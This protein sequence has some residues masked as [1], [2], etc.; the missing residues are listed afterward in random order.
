MIFFFRL[1]YIFNTLHAKT[2]ALSITVS[3]NGFKWIMDVTDPAWLLHEY[4]YS[5]WQTLQHMWIIVLG[6]RNELFNERHDNLSTHFLTHTYTHTYMHTHCTLYT[7]IHVADRQGQ[8]HPS[9]AFITDRT[10]HPNKLQPWGLGTEEGERERARER[11]YIAGCNQIIT[12]LIVWEKNW[13]CPC[14]CVWKG[15]RHLKSL[16]DTTI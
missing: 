13:R 15:E 2:K 16:A 3:N 1:P 5:V 10:V 9:E 8:S 12:T 7:D 4:Q 11:A 6:L 14:I